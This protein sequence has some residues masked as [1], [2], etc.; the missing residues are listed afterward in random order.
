MAEPIQ[1]VFGVAPG[2]DFPAIVARGLCARFAGQGPEELARVTLVANSAR[3]RKRLTDAF[4]A[5]GALLLPTITLVTDF[6]A[7]HPALWAIDTPRLA[8]IRRRLDLAKLLVPL[9]EKHPTLVPEAHALDLADSLAALLDEMQSEGVPFQALSELNVADQSGHWQQALAF[10]RIATDFA[11]SDRGLDPE[12]LQRHKAELLVQAWQ[13]APPTDPILIVGSTGSRGTTAMLMEAVTNLPQGS[14]ILPGFDAHM[15]QS[16]WNRLADDHPEEDHPQYRYAKLL[17]RLGLTAADVQNWTQDAAPNLARNRLVSLALRPAPVTH[18]WLREGPTLGSLIDATQSMTMVNAPDPR[19]EANAIA[20]RLRQAAEDGT[21]A[22]LIT[23]DRTLTRRVAAALDRW[24]IIADDSA[25]VP[26]PLTAPGRLLLQV[27]DMMAN[28]IAADTLLAILKHP[29]TAATEDDRGPHLLATRAYELQL[30]KKGPPYPTPADIQTWADAHDLEIWGQWLSRLLT[31]ETPSDLPSLIGLHLKIAEGLA[32]GATAQNPI[33]L[34]DT[35][36][37]R[38]ARDAMRALQDAAQSDDIFDPVDYARL[39]RKHLATGQV[40]AAD[41]THP[42]ILIWGT[43]EARVQGAELVILGG[44]NDAVWPEAA[45]IDP[46]LNRAMRMQA[47]LLLPERQIG[48]SAHDFQQAVAAPEVWITRSVKTDE[49]ETIPSRWVNRLETLMS[50]LPDQGGKEALELMQA[51]GAIWID[52]AALL[53]AGP[54]VGRVARPAPIPPPMARPRKLSVTEIKTLIRDPYAIYAKHVLR[55]RGLDPLVGEADARMRGIIL[56]DV[57]E[58]F[59]LAGL[60]TDEEQ[61]LK[62]LEAHADRILTDVPWPSARR[63]WRARLMRIAPWLVDSERRRQRDATVAAT[64]V[65]GQLEIADL[66]F[67]LRGTADRIDQTADGAARIYDYKTGTLPTAGQQ[68]TFDKQLMLETRMLENGA[69]DDVPPTQVDRATYIGLGAKPAQVDGIDFGDDD[70]GRFLTLL[71]S[72]LSDTHGF[73]ARRAMSHNDVGGDYDHLS[74]YGEWAV[75]DAP[76]KVV[77]K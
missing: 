66:N 15:P 29:L 59:I 41:P 58:A 62:D 11:A 8:P 64:E 36:N 30:R 10:L 44:L 47:G 57:M 33:E 67:T 72:M 75:T 42:N 48:L 12:G 9:I 55:L 77:L 27:A 60:S 4:T 50:G 43:L 18:H 53:D 51:R 16:V 17:G 73:T 61:A 63:L 46:W 22:A 38:D 24:G 70:W 34:W 5:Q 74:R 32:G 54:N 69:F 26:L 7:L 21:S 49:A 25:G 23:P 40:R 68:K 52:Q 1:G 37:G 45:A 19:A 3:M 6:E 14:L 13:S 28:G 65:K 39:V 35:A 31:F 20:L 2:L 71:Q 56:H 76:D